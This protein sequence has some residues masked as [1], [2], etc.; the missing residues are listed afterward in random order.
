MQGGEKDSE[1]R[2]SA[3]QNRHR[4]DASTSC[5]PAGAAAGSMAAVPAEY[6][7]DAVPNA[8]SASQSKVWS[9]PVAVAILIF[10]LSSSSTFRRSD[11]TPQAAKD[12]STN[13]RSFG[14][15]PPATA[16]MLLQ[17]GLCCCVCCGCCCASM[18]S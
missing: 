18:P 1:K 14:G 16:A 17:I 11:S 3:S 9:D 12:R 6:C 2:T 7:G 4:Q 13:A 5:C 10:C 15:Q 8:G